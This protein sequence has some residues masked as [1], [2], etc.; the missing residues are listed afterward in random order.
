MIIPSGPVDKAMGVHLQRIYKTSPTNAVE[1]VSRRDVV[2]IS[3]FSALVEHGTACAAALPE[4]R[5]D[6]VQHAIA[7]LR[8]GELPGGADVASAMINSSVEGQVQ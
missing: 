5:A 1:Q 2:S 4:V 7:L 8:D 3:R 6:R